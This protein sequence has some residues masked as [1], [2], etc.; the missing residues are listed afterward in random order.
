MELNNKFT[1]GTKFMVAP[2]KNP[3]TGQ[4]YATMFTSSNF[5]TQDTTEGEIRKHLN[6]DVKDIYE[7]EFIVKQDGE[8]PVFQVL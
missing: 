3:T 2:V 7:K 6:S 8:N 1:V 4:S 5:F